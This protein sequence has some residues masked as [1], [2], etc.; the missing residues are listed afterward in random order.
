MKQGAQQPAGLLEAVLPLPH[1]GEGPAVCLM[2]AFEPGSADPEREASVRDVVNAAGDFGRQRRVAV[3]IAEH[4]VADPQALGA[5]RGGG[6]E[7]EGFVGLAALHRLAA[8]GRDE[9]VGEPDRVVAALSIVW[10]TR[11]MSSHEVR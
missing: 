3:G 7:A 9:V 5:G 2:L 4:E 10:A 1:R 6:R 11:R 8:V